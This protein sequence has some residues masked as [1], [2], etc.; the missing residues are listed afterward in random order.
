MTSSINSTSST[1][2]T[3]SYKAKGFTGLATGFDTES[4]VEAMTSDVQAKID[5]VQQEQQK[6]TWKQDAYRDV[7]TALTDFQ[8]KYFSYSS[9]TNILSSNFYNCTTMVAGG[10]NAS[11]ISVSGVSSTRNSTYSVTGISQLAKTATKIC[12]GT[13]TRGDITTGAITFG[14]RPVSTVT[15]GSISIKYGGN[16]YTASIPY[17]ADVT[18]ANTLASTLNAAM[19]KTN[20]SIGGTLADKLKFSASGDGKMYLGYQDMSDSNSFSISAGST[21]V[22][23]AL[24]MKSGDTPGVV[25]SVEATLPLLGICS[26]PFSLD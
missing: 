11:K 15:G 16:V 7:I 26:E 14:D 24:H 5:K 25:S 6:Y 21:E 17:D 23:N 8:S 4:V 10:N 9:T 12:E 19:A 22:L 13:K 18:D 3:A 2:S 20:L 1:S